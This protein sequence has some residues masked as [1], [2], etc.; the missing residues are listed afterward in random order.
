MSS[1]NEHNISIDHEKCIGCGL[2]VKDC[3]ARNI[4][5]KDKKA[6]ILAQDCILCGHCVAVCPKAAVS[7]SGYEEEPVP[8]QGIRLDPEAVLEVIRQRRSVRQFQDRE[9]PKA[10]LAQVL[11]AG[12]ITHTAKN[13]QDVS[14]IVL[15]REKSKTEQMA[16]NLFRRIRPLAGLFNPLARRVPIDD[17]FFF[18]HA[19]IAI[20]IAAKAPIDGALA[21]QNMEFAAEANGLGVLFSGYF[22]TAA[23]A[24][25]KIR[26]AL[27]IPKGKK[28]V[29]TLV[30]GYPKVSYQRSA[31]R[32]PLDIQY[33]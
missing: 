29:T 31:Q 5:L 20:V 19:P 22:T 10:V 4:T 32:E 14:L 27:G 1:I 8:S 2:C 16:V 3:V 21:A 6:G 7:I 33:L 28:A 23:G 26:K 30:L 13:M 24:S 17:H 25:R 12:R 15:D 11:E 9:I 18:F